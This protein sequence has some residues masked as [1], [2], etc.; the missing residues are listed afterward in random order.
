M[1]LKF[2][3]ES[4]LFS[5]QKP[6]TSAE[7]REL[8]KKASE[9]EDA[10]EARDFKRTSL[11][12]IESALAELLAEHE[13]GGR[14]FRLM[15]VAGAWQFAS[16]PEFAP[17]IKALIGQKPRPPKLSA[18]A[19]ETLAIIAYRQPV[20]RAEMEQIRGVAV[21]GVMGTLLER[22]LIEQSGKAEAPGRP[23]LY[24]TTP[25]FLE[26]FGLGSLEDLPDAG[27]LRRIPVKKPEELLTV[28]PDLATAPPEQL[29]LGESP[30]DTAGASSERASLSNN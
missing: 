21:D 27:E 8:L 29:Q 9:F 18:P 6:L 20:T 2:I 5:S 24:S 26:Y 22:G 23:A 12:N 15:T 30:A 13:R 3:I 7:I 14:S 1:E 16:Q 25:L 10:P 11:D 19:L 4:I 17:W 28:D